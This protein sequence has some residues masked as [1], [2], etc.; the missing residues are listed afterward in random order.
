MSLVHVEQEK[1]FENY[2]GAQ[3]TLDPRRKTDSCKHGIGAVRSV[4][5]LYK[6]FVLF[7]AFE[8]E[9]ILLFANTPLDWAPHPP[10]SPPTLVR[11][12]VF[13][14]DHLV[15]QYLPYN[16]SDANIV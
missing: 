14:P 1:L 13:H 11:N 8:Q 4:L 5:G 2:L 9:S 7:E 12:I 10:P 16:I 3:G 6:I 15:L